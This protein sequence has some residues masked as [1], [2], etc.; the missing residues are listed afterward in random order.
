MNHVEAARAHLEGMQTGAFAGMIDGVLAR[1]GVLHAEPECFLLA[2]RVEGEAGVLHV[3]Y[4]HGEML[5]I[6]RVLGG[7]GCEVV[8]WAR[9]YTGRAGYGVRRR[10][11]KDLWRHKTFGI[12]KNKRES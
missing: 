4:A 9:A 12:T 8:E 6:M 3:A 5:A 11:L 7:L 10:P 1:G 2:W